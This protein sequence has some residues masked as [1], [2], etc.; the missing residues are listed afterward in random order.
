MKGIFRRACAAVLAALTTGAVMAPTVTF[1]ADVP[2]TSSQAY[3][4]MDADTGQVLIGKR[5]NAKMY[6]ASITKVLT[7]ALVLCDHSPDERVRVGE[8]VYDILPESTYAGLMP[9]EEM[10]VRDLLY[11]AMLPS[12]NDAANALA[13]FEDGS[14]A[15]FAGR[16]NEKAREAGAEQ[17]HFV[18][19][20]GLPDKDH[21]TTAADFARI[22]AWALTVPD[23][24]TYFGA[25]EYT[26]SP[27]NL[28]PAARNWGTY[29]CLTVESA[30]TYEGA[31]GGKTG[32]TDDAENT[33][34]SAAERDGLRL[35]LV[36]LKTPK[37]Y[38]KFRNAVA[39]Y[40][41]CFSHFQRV[42]YTV[43]A[44]E[45]DVGIPYVEGGE[46]VGE[47][48]LTLPKSVPVT[49]AKAEKAEN[50]YAKLDIAEKYEAGKD[51]APTL[52]VGL[53]ETILREIP[54]EYNVRR[55]ETEAPAKAAAAAGEGVPAGSVMK[56]ALW[57]LLGGAAGI[58]LVLYALRVFFR[59]RR[60]IRRRRRRHRS[61]L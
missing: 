53:G 32:L 5:E 3:V 28:Q 12:A 49:I 8:E 27:T 46:T 57:I 40:D 42:D 24:V 26:M 59:V 11:A 52:Q 39:L 10:T 16:M 47:V 29:D 13:V 55:F 18:N 15:D 48:L 23:F 37:K 31:I 9:G 21:Y 44:L 56:A 61:A 25:P 7:C 20:S 58:F 33:Y 41:Y 36:D 34:V 30:F 22:T 54:L 17:S 4:V 35:V 51:I 2:A 50:V 19:P 43:P 1:A 38:D 14:L 6:P 60:M 45:H